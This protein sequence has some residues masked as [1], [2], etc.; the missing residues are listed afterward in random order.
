MLVSKN[1][2]GLK[3]P[4]KHDTK[5]ARMLVRDLKL[6][7]LPIVTDDMP[8][9]SL[10]NMFHLGISRSASR[11]LFRQ[12]GCLGYLLTI[13]RMAVVIPAPRPT[14]IGEIV[15]GKKPVAPC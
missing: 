12:L 15:V 13:S 2:I 4:D 10:L 1:L 5:T 3:I 11:C 6:Y 9:Y 8:A 14:A 7:P